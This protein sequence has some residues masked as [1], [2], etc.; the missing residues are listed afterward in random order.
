MKKSTNTASLASLC[1]GLDLGPASECSSRLPGS[2]WLI[3]DASLFVWGWGQGVGPE[4]AAKEASLFGKAGQ[5][6]YK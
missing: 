5:A 2:S 1:Q 3:A 6:L 4:Y